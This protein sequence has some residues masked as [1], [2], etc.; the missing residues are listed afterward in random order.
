M[1]ALEPF[2]ATSSVSSPLG[3]PFD[4][5]SLLIF[6]LFGPRL[7][8]A[9]IFIPTSFNPIFR[10]SSLLSAMFLSLRSSKV[11]SLSF[12]FPANG[13]DGL[14]LSASIDGMISEESRPSSSSTDGV[15]VEEQL[16]FSAGGVDLEEQLFPLFP[17]E[18]ATDGRGRSGAKEPT[19]SPLSVWLLPTIQSFSSGSSV[20]IEQRFVLF[21]LYYMILNVAYEN[22]LPGTHSSFSARRPNPV[23]TRPTT[24]FFRGLDR[25]DIYTDGK[26]L[27]LYD[28]IPSILL[29]HMRQPHRCLDPHRQGKPLKTIRFHARYYRWRFASSAEDIEWP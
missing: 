24:S 27:A 5:K 10:R 8:A 1:E 16:P 21:N 12:P 20:A 18:P 4:S 26:Y 6:F 7:L 23:Q 17:L 19:L 9:N 14:F 22:M 25:D 29:T 3:S 2:A 15:D 28:Q 11:S 13:V